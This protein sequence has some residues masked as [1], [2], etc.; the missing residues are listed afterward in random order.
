M[1]CSQNK[2]HLLPPR[3]NLIN[4][5]LSSIKKSTYLEIGVRCGANLFQIN[6]SRK[7]GVDPD[8]FF[9]NRSLIKALFHRRNWF[10]EMFKLESDNFFSDKGALLFKKSGIDVVFIDGMHTYRQSLKDATNS[11]RYLNKGGVIIFH[12][13][14]PTS[15]IVAKPSIPSQK[16][17][18]NGDVWKTIYH[19]RQFPEHFEC[20]T[21]KS[22]Q[23][24]GVLKMKNNIAFD[25][26]S[27]IQFRQDFQDLTYEYLSRNRVSTIGLKEFPN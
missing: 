6:A 3:T 9:S 26:T 19:F 14:N 25:I 16:I 4:R 5:H 15:K 13:C 20:Y 10:L 18:W 23:G 2:K 12:D 11:L 7:I 27:K 1:F 24:L 22:D 21:Y 17:N 8:Y